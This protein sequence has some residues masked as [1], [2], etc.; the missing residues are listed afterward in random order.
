MT[1]WQGL[2]STLGITMPVFIVVLAGL[3][4]RR[5]NWIDDAFIQTGSSLVFRV[6]LPL[7]MFLAVADFGIDWGR[8]GALV[9]FTASAAIGGFLLV[10]L[11]ARFL[12]P[13]A[14]RGV[15]TQGAFRSNLGIVGI[16][17]C[18]NAFPGEGLAVGAVILAVVTPLYNVLSIYGLAKSNQQAGAKLSWLVVILDVLKNPLILSIAAGLAFNLLGFSLPS[19]MDKSAHYLAQMTLPLALLS[20]GG[21]LSLTSIRQAKMAS[22]YAV[23]WKLLGLPVLVVLIARMLGFTDVVLGCILL[24]FASPTAAASYV[25]VR[26]MGG[27]HQLASNIIILT[28]LLS[29]FTVSLLLYGSVVFGWI[30]FQGQ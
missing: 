6:C 21:S 18:A 16:A 4:F 10:W 7:L 2:V 14:E 17:L 24:M 23:G 20:I 28:T 12:F 8:H 3:A 9:G 11:S 27:N 25:M 30:G 22:F 26:T 19:V 13:L 1:Y 29:A 15:I 5:L